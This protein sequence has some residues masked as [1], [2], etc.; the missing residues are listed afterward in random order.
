M[1]SL[2]KSKGFTVTSLY[3]KSEPH[4][5]WKYLSER[6]T[7]WIAALSLLAFVTGNMVGQHGWHVFWKSVMGEGD[8]SLITYTGTAPPLAQV[9]DIARWAKYGGDIHSHS[10][11]EVPKDFLVP[12]P[13]YAPHGHD[14][15]A[16]AQLRLTY[17]VEHLGTYATGRGEGSHPG[18]D[19]SV[20]EGTPVQAIANGIVARVG[21]DKGGYGN[22]VVIKHPNVPDPKR[23]AEKTALYSTYAHLSTSIVTEGSVVRKGDQIALSGQTGFAT[24]PH[25]HFQLDRDNAP[26]HPYW[27]F[28]SA[29]ASKAGM[30]FTQA[31]DAGL[32][33]DR[34]L[35]FTAD[36]MLYVQAH[37]A[38]KGTAVAVASSSSSRPKITIAD[39]KHLRMAR[40]NANRTLVAVADDISQTP[41]PSGTDV[42]PA[43]SASS[44]SEQAPDRVPASVVI[45]HG[46]SFTQARSWK[47]VILTLL[48]RQGNQILDP[49][50]GRVLYLRTAYGKAEFRPS[51]IN[52]SEFRDGK[53]TVEILPFGEQTVVIEVAPFGSLSKPMRF[54][55]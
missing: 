45:T 34:G 54:V 29:E 2:A 13:T 12:L 14:L 5:A 8:E 36:P 47:T 55:R 18:V 48:D 11:R 28:S 31:V 27:L 24:A 25:L 37:M 44:S 40:L 17:F 32:Y 20:P 21:F 33:R 16:D 53:A 41:I 7:F 42:R 22:F 30:N 38:D 51:A 35:E 39:R 26:W 23:P 46:G 49:L 19:I 9:P 4:A 6:A 43:A 3:T 10:F 50:P 1:P 15:N 52:T